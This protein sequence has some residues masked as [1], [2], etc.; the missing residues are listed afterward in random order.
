MLPVI[1]VAAHGD[2]RLDKSTNETA[3]AVSS[4]QSAAGGGPP[5][6]EYRVWHSYGLRP[7]LAGPVAPRRPS[8]RCTLGAST[9]AP[10]VLPTRRP[11]SFR[12]CRV[13]CRRRDGLPP[14]SCR[15]GL[16]DTKRDAGKLLRRPD[17]KIGKVERSRRVLRNV[18]VIAGTRIPTAA[19]KRYKEAG[20]TVDQ[21][22]AEYP[23]LTANDVEAALAYEENSAA[24]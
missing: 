22:I 18:P 12:G 2:R 11:R 1:V 21:I 16:A 4:P 24:A 5:T 10:E 8:Q 7:T 15:A 3:T 17:A 23:D 9:P 14:L 19:I 13:C 20:F 6:A